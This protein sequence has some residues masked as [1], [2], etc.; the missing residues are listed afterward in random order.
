VETALHSS[1]THTRNQGAQIPREA[2]PFTGTFWK[3]LA[4]LALVLLAY[5]PAFHAGFIWDDDLYVVDNPLLYL[6]DGWWRIWFTLEQTSQ[7]FPL[8]YSLLRMGYQ[9]WGLEPTGYHLL[10]IS[11]HIGNGVLFGV[12]LRK[13]R[14]QGVLIAT[15]LFLLHPVQVETV[16]WITEV[17]NLL[18]TFFFLL[19]AFFWIRWLDRLDFTD[20]MRAETGRSA[21]RHFLPVL[22]CYLLA[23]SAK[24][25]ACTFAAIMPLILWVRGNR[26]RRVHFYAMLP[27]IVAGLAAGFLSMWIEASRMLVQ[28]PEFELSLPERLGLIAR[29]I[30]FYPFKL[31]LPLKL[32]FSYPK[33]DLQPPE[34]LLSLAGV[35]LISLCFLGF[36]KKRG[37][38]GWIAL[39]LA[40]LA[41]L[42]PMLGFIDCYTF[43]YTYVADHYQYLACGIVFAG[44]GTLLTKHMNPKVLNWLIPIT[45]LLCAGFTWKQAAI[46][47]SKGT[48][49]G[50]TLEKNPQSWMAMNNLGAWLGQN[51]EQHRAVLLYEQALKLKPDYPEALLNMAW[52]HMTRGRSNEAIGMAYQAVQSKPDEARNYYHLGLLYEASG[53]P[54][55]GIRWLEKTLEVDPKNLQAYMELGRILFEQG[56]RMES[57]QLLRRSISKRSDSAELQNQLGIALSASGKFSEAVPHFKEAIRLKPHFA[58]ARKNLAAAL[59]SARRVP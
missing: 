25:T 1:K 21:F 27:I 42:A 58:D 7:Y 39:P 37:E 14:L 13:L 36:W 48:L 15:G 23:L 38:K 3:L 45:L 31:I 54:E 46:Y 30:L 59:A 10:N 19:S 29:N 20:S 57:I 6:P 5:T 55:S 32:T 24:T 50:D 28:G 56:K 9:C 47:E 8:T 51:R 41:I 2:S 40:Y 22:L 43:R 53:K 34:I 18:S 11:I 17:K 33:W 52:S 16:A 26:F 12:V 4:L 49:W 44:I 35:I